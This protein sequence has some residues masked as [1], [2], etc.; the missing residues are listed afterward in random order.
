[1]TEMNTE[2]KVGQVW[3]DWDKRFRNDP[4]PRKVRI[5][6]IDEVGRRAICQ[7]V[8]TGKETRISL[9]RLKPTTTGYKLIEEAVCP[10]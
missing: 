8:D 1:M 5:M 6:R 10:K 4:F 9:D 2:V 3:Q 7:N